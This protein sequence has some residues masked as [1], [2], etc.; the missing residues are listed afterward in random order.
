[1]ISAGRPSIAAGM[2]IARPAVAEAVAAE[3]ARTSLVLVADAGFGKTTALQDGLAAGDLRAAWVACERAHREPGRLLAAVIDALRAAVPGVA[4][5]LHERLAG[6]LA[7]EAVAALAREAAV[8][9]DRLLAD[10]LVLVLDDAEVLAGAP[11]LDDVVAQL[12]VTDGQLR[13]AIAS[14]RPLELPLARLRAAGRI[15]ELGAG[16]LAFD[17][18][19]CAA[20]LRLRRGEDPTTEEI[21][22]V[23]RT[24]EGWPLGVALI[25]S[26]PAGAADA[27]TRADLLAYLERELLSTLDAPSREALATAAVAGE[28]DPA[29]AAALELPGDLLARQPA[30]AGFVAATDDGGRRLHPLL[31]ELL[32]RE[33][34]RRP[35]AARRGAR[36]ALAGARAAQGRTAEAIEL[37]LE[38]EAW[39]PRPRPWPARAPPPCGPRRAPWPAGST[40]CHPAARRTRGSRCSARRSS[41]RAATR[42]ARAGC[43]RPRSPRSRHPATAPASGRPAWR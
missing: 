1:M 31:R 27:A 14:R 17:A 15:A 38:A 11:A 4:D 25:A 37:W 6:G 36:A 24:T 22:G 5:V 32:L 28:L 13:L 7:A 8:E 16:R 21:A 9:C 23:Q 29:A 12:L 40:G 18:G 10:P 19:E 41:W 42:T 33:E 20:L 35:A 26:G 39:T 2:R 34:G 3:L 30:L 43:S